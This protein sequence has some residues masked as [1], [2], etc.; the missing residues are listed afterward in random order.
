[1]R[2]AQN[3]IGLQRD[4]YLDFVSCNIE[5]YVINQPRLVDAQYF[6]VEVFVYHGE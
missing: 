6:A 2:A 4:K 5:I 3:R 1:M